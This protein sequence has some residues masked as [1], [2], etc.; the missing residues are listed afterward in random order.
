MTWRLKKSKFFI[1]L[2]EYF[3]NSS[4]D[5]CHFGKLSTVSYEIKTEI[6]M[7]GHSLFPW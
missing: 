2:A 7:I 1:V 5:F 6:D 4:T 3:E